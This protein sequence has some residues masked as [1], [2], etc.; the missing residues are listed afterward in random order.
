MATL[1]SIPADIPSVHLHPGKITPGVYA[2]A[3]QIL[4]KS[5]DKTTVEAPLF[6][7]ED[8]LNCQ[9]IISIWHA[10]VQAVAQKLNSSNFELR[11]VDVY[12]VGE[13]GLGY[14][15]IPYYTDDPF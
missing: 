4:R 2:R 9:D 1:E 3:C 15:T 14:L 12:V 8:Y 10:A 6:R 7:R 5:E 11:Y 13:M